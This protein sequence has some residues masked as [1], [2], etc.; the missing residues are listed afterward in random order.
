MNPLCGS[1]EMRQE[2]RRFE[3]KGINP[4]GLI[5]WGVGDAG[6]EGWR[7]AGVLHASK[8]STAHTF[9]SPLC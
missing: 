2:R 8:E 7:R 6:G 1:D 5:G 4:G 3:E 9:S